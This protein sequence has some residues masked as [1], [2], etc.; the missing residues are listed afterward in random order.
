MAKKRVAVIFGGVSTEHTVS[1]VSAA[2]VLGNL[3]AEKYE[4]FMLGITLDGRWLLFD[5]ELSEIESGDWE[6]NPS[7]QMAFISPDAAVHGIVIPR[8]NTVLPIDVAFPVLHG[9]NGEDGTIQG[10]LKLA[11]IPCVGCGVA[12]AAV[13]GRAVRLRLVERRPSVVIAEGCDLG[14]DGRVAGGEAADD[15]DD[16]DDL[17]G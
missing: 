9:A 13:A 10:L 11:Q 4:I 3:S 16:E 5:G 14:C 7:N 1:L 8:T 6:K 2:S 12:G 17:D 15:P